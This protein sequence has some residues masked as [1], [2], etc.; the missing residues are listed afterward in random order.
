MIILYP[1]SP[2]LEI[3]LLLAKVPGVGK[4]VREEPPILVLQLPLRGSRACQTKLTWESSATG[5]DAKHR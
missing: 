4:D 1:L 3:H 2:I 5:L